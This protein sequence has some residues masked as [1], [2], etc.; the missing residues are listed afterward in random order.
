MR[1]TIVE[2][3]RQSDRFTK[4][5]KPGSSGL[6]IYKDRFNGEI[7]S[8]FIDP[9]SV[10]LDN[11]HINLVM[12]LTE[13]AMMDQPAAATNSPAQPVIAGVACQWKNRT[14]FGNSQSLV[15]GKVT[16]GSWSYDGAA[17]HG[18]ALKY[19]VACKLP[20]IKSPKT[21]FESEEAARAILI[22][23][24]TQWFAALGIAIPQQS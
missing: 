7:S 6:F 21:N 3:S 15:M 13:E 17:P 23:M 1:E 14:G 11:C 2:T 8:L 10:L 24:A 20:G 9:E 22:E 19:A 18:S 4:L 16:L 5:P 12:L